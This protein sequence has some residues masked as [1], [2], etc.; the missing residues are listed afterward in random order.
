MDAPAVPVAISRKANSVPLIERHHSTLHR[1]R[2]RHV[3]RQH[4]D[5]SDGEAGVVLSHG[6]AD[7]GS[8]A[9][10]ALIISA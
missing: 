5:Q 3:T 4:P 9:Q 8:R 7:R 1:C 2:V 6:N 10:H